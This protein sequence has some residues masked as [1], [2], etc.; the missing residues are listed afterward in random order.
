MCDIK[1]SQKYILP[2]EICLSPSFF[3][4]KHFLGALFEI[5]IKLKDGFFIPIRPNKKIFFTS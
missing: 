3:W 4:S 1:F 5:G 2:I